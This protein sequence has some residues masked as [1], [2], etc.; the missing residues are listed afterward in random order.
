ME[1]HQQNVIRRRRTRAE[2]QHILAEFLGSGMNQDEFCRNRGVCRS[3]L[4]RYLRKKRGEE[5]PALN[6]QLV[7]VELVNVRGA[8]FSRWSGLAVVVGSGRKI[9]VAEGFDAGTLERL[10]N[11]LERT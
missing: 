6:T 9:E 2:V 4:C 3:T 8:T 1:S 11:V 5:K 7:P 10:L